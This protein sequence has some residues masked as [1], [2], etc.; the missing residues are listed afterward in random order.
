MYAPYIM[1]AINSIDSHNMGKKKGLC[2]GD[3]FDYDIVTQ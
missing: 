2:R 3:L 1:K